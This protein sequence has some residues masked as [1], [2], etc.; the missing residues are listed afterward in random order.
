MRVLKIVGV[1]LLALGLV[2]GLASPALAA[3]PDWMPPRAGNMPP[4]VLMGEVIDIDEGKTFFV[5]QS[6]WWEVTVS[7]DSDTQ[8]L[9]APIPQRVVSLAE[10]LKELRQQSQE[11]FGLGRWLRPFVEKARLFFKAHVPWRVPSLA[12]HRLELRQQGWEKLGLV[13]W[14]HPFAEEATFDDIAVGTQVVVRAVPAEDNPVAKLVL[15]IEPTGYGCISG[16]ITDISSVDKTITIAPA[17]GDEDIILSYNE[18]T[19]FV[20]RGI[21]RLEVGQSIRA[22]YDE[23]MIAKVVFVPVEMP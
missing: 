3:P 20:L 14:F 12:R 15:I 11:R 16:T 13:R 5:I 7:V 6:E 4:K 9:E 10:H 18:G 19:R 2:L 21:P 17:D 23:E 1:S 8:Y 22:I